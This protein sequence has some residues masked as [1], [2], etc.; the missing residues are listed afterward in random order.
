MDFAGHKDIDT[1]RESLH[2]ARCIT[3][4]SHTHPDGDALGSSAGMAL[5]LQKNLGKTVA[6]VLPDAPAE[7]L[8][9]ILP[10][11]VRFLCHTSEAE[12]CER[13]IAESDLLILTDGNSFSRTEG[14]ESV[15]NASPARKVLIDHHVGPDKD[16]FSLVFSY[17][18]IS[19]ASE[20]T[21]WILKAVGP[22][23]LPEDCLEALLTGMTTDTNNFAN[24]VF[25]STF[26][27]ASEI[28][29]QGVDRDAVLQKI[30]NNYR[31]NRLRLFGYMQSEA[32]RILPGGAAFMVL[33][34]ET[35]RRFDLREGETEGLVNLPLSVG[36]V[37]LSL[38]LKEDDGHF[39]V[40]IRSKKGTSAR[41]LAQ[42]F[43]HGGGHENAAGGKLF[44]PAD[45]PSPADAPAFLETLLTRYCA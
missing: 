35:Q 36:K 23:P 27:M 1:L 26:R 13:Q 40:S 22:Q 39:R 34:K 19:S 12:A 6:C 5:F 29:A 11:S 37:R 33:D 30:F 38:L 9:F 43:F 14:L 18:D 7:Q 44:F 17:P 3:V 15:L 24:S 2:T 20:L 21:Y 41:E 31:E 10:E 16:S 45:I 8:R 4:L 25:P 28:I 42:A 32:L